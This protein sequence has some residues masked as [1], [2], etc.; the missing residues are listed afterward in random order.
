[1][2]KSLASWT[3]GITLLAAMPSANWNLLMEA[4]RHTRDGVLRLLTVG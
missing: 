2:K 3:L 4:M 1:M